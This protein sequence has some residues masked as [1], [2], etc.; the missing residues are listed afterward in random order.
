MLRSIWEEEKEKFING[1]MVRRIIVINIGVFILVNVI[2]LA[3]YI[4]FQFSPHDPLTRYTSSPFYENYLSFFKFFSMSA[5]WMFVLTH[6]WILIT[7]MFLHQG[8]WHILWNMLIMYW[9]GRIVG[10]FIGNQRI[11]PIYL[12]SGLAGG[13]I[14]FVTA[15]LLNYTGPNGYAYGASGAVM[16][17]VVA[18]GTIAPEYVMRLLLLGDV[19]LKYIV[20]ALVL[21]DLFSLASDVNTGGHFAHLGGALLGFLFVRQLQEGNDWALPVNNI[22]DRINNLFSGL[23]RSNRRKPKVVYKNTSRIRKNQQSGSSRRGNQRSDNKQ[24]YEEKLNSILD[25]I[26]VSGYESLTEEEKEFLFNAS[27]R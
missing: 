3:F 25:K 4:A 14:F 12:I 27:K 21:L 10:D 6:P 2:N 26:K 1:N 16:G 17:M 11:L 7:S 24:N 13:L 8:F 22:L 15:N 9:F 18:A 5:D 19:K 23:G 20:V